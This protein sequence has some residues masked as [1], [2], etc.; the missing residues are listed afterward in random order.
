[1]T[2]GIAFVVV[3]RTLQGLGDMVCFRMLIEMKQGS[4][5]STTFVT[6]VG[7]IVSMGTF[8]VVAQ[9]SLGFGGNFAIITL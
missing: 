6:I 4:K 7:T 3:E 8:N 1:M 2:H 9:G 5:A